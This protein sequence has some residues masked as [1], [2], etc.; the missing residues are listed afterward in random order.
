MI[1]C[2]SKCLGVTAYS[3]IVHIIA[4][5]YIIVKYMLT[6]TAS[7]LFVFIVLFDLVGT[8]G[9][10]ENLFSL[11]ER[12][13]LR[14][15]IRSQKKI[16]DAAFFC[17]TR[18]TKPSTIFCF[19]KNLRFVSLAPR[20]NRKMNTRWYPFFYGREMEIYHKLW[21]WFGSTT[22]RLKNSIEYRTMMMAS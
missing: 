14:F 16:A 6:C 13:A 11:S 7:N 5:I 15:F 8:C 10:F 2:L 18:Y 9:C 17:Y 22:L 1:V 4:Y 3:T 21:R 20:E 12:T 19:A